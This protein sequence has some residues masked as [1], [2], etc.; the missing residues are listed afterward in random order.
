MVTRLGAV[1]FGATRRAVLSLL[2]T[3]PDEV[4]YLRQIVRLTGVGL[5]P[6]QRE[7]AAL[8]VGGIVIRTGT[9]AACYYQANTACPIFRELQS[10][11]TKTARVH[12]T[13]RAAIEPI[14]SQIDLAFVFGS[15]AAGEQNSF[16]DIDLILVAADDE[17]QLRDVV[18][19]L[20]PTHDQL[21]RA[22]NPILYRRGEMRQK[23]RSKHHFLTRVM[24]SPKVFIIGSDDELKRM[25]EKRLAPSVQAGS[26]RNRR[27]VRG[28]KARPARLRNARTQ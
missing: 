13:L 15:V 11:I 1:L 26:K 14:N 12:E 16:S 3:R 6:V 21:G 25:A 18:G 7:L 23:L 20:R 24:E 27:A 19:A 22:I 28:G 8:T 10:I 17:L 2:L 5:G 9:A 4:F